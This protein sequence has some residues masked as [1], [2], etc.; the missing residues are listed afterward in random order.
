MK[1]TIAAL[2]ILATLMA[3]NADAK[4]RTRILPKETTAEQIKH[5]RKHIPKCLKGTYIEWRQNGNGP[6]DMEPNAFM[7][8]SGSDQKWSNGLY[9]FATSYHTTN[10]DGTVVVEFYAKA[11]CIETLGDWGR[12]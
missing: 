2:A 9:K 3:T 4:M 1:T 5:L 10:L 12:E 7:L 6:T 8:I 11:Y